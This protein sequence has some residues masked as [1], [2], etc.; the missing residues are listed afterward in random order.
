MTAGRY[1]PTEIK[2]NIYTVSQKKYDTNFFHITSSNIDRI[3]KFFHL[4]TLQKICN[5]VCIKD[6]AHLA[7][8]MSLQDLVKY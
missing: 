7:S 5:E 6:L 4:L 2:H 1:R 8:N 3:S